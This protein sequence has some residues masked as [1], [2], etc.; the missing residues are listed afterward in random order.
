MQELAQEMPERRQAEPLG[1][2]SAAL[3]GGCP[4][5]SGPVTRGSLL[6]PRG[7]PACFGAVNQRQYFADL[8]CGEGGAGKAIARR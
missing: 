3:A 8:F 4:S 2:P 7:R 5:K 6:R 1:P